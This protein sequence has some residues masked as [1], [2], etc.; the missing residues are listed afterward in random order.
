MLVELSRD[1]AIQSKAWPLVGRSTGSGSAPFW[2]QHRLPDSTLALQ[3]IYTPSQMKRTTALPWP[4]C[5]RL[6]ELKHTLHKIT[7]IWNLWFSQRKLWILMSSR[8]WLRILGCLPPFHKN[9]LPP[10]SGL[11]KGAEQRRRWKA[12][13]ETVC[14]SETSVNYRATRSHIKENTS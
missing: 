9:L 11:K 13:T 7:R 4:S 2:W 10:S 3:Y 12:K 6:W 14:Y 8:V 5:P 1:I